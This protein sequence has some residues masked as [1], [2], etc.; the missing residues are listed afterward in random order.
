M[1]DGEELTREEY[2]KIFEAGSKGIRIPS[3]EE[4]AREEIERRKSEDTKHSEQSAFLYEVDIIK[5][6]V[7]IIK[8]QH[9]E[10]FEFDLNGVLDG[11]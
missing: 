8:T 1:L 9:N 5:T 10:G 11:N 6:E 7:D 3:K 4:L 2:L